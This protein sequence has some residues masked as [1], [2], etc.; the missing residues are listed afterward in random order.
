MSGFFVY[1]DWTTEDVPRPFYVGKGNERRIKF[2]RRNRLHENIANKHGLIRQVVFETDDEQLAL[3]LEQ[4]L[5]EEYKTYVHGG[6]GYWGACP[7]CG[8]FPL[9]DQK[10]PKP[11]LD[12][13]L[14]DICGKR[15][16]KY[17]HDFRCDHCGAAILV[18]PCLSGDDMEIH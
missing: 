15:F 6:E 11:K 10:M 1:V 12:F 14:C 2:P 4:R 18:E 13:W 16:D 9:A 17:I 8:L 3:A 5:I 7:H